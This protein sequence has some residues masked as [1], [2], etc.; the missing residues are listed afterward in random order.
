[1]DDGVGKVMAALKEANVEDNTFVFFTSDNGYVSIYV[2]V[3]M[4]VF[5]CVCIYIYICLCVFVCA[6]NAWFYSYL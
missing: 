4:S 1:M 5:V 3:R 6:P 2:C